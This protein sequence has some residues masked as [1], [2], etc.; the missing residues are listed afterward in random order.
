MTNIVD[1]PHS[2]N[3]RRRTPPE[4]FAALNREFQFDIDLAADETNH[5]CDLWLGP[6]SPMYDNSLAVGWSSIQYM[7]NE[8]ERVPPYGPGSPIVQQAKCGWLNPPYSRGNL[9]QFLSKCVQE[10]SKGFTTVTITPYM[11]SE[12]WF[13][14]LHEA[15]EIR[16]IPHRVGFLLADGTKDNSAKFPSA[17]TVFR[18]QPGIVRGDP[19]RVVWTYRER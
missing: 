12:G 10:A 4:L 6:G 9:E 11:P 13:R 15:S 19:R 5:L 16:E 14:I 8:G 7:W 3:D 17:I 18:P 2:K 1:H